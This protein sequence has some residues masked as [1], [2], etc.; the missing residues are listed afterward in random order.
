MAVAERADGARQDLDWEAEPILQTI[1]KPDNKR[2]S[3]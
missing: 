1:R 3:F 2:A